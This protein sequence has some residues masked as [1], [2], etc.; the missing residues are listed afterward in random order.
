[1]SE[2]L[3]PVNILIGDRTYRIR[4][5][6]KDEEGV[7]RTVKKVNDKILEF[8]TSFA[9]KDMQDYIAMVM[10]WLASLTLEQPEAWTD[11][12]DL[13]TELEKIEKTIDSCQPDSNLE[14]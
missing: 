9:G 10:I 2:A 14:I 11:F 5:H 3:I 7:R 4:I 12:S 8:K 13:D 6:P 1:M